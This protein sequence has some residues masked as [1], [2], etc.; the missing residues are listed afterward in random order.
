MTDGVLDQRLQD[1]RRHRHRKRSLVDVPANVEPI[2][3]AFAL[4]IDVPSH[5]IDFGRE[6]HQVIARTVH[7]CA[8]Q[9]AEA[10]QHLERPPVVLH[11][12]QRGNR[13]ESVEQEVRMNLQAQR[14]EL[15]PRQLDFQP[16]FT[17]LEHTRAVAGADG[18]TR[19]QQQSDDEQVDDEDRGNLLDQRLPEPG[20][21]KGENG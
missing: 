1:Q 7:G 4:E 21:R 18:A 14:F 9:F 8:H 2:G 6:R 10:Q 16:R 11:A 17:T 3:E 12:D 15:G 5:E 13:I 20:R 19:R